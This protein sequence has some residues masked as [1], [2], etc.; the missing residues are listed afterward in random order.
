M[1]ETSDRPEPRAL[2]DAA[3]RRYYR[4]AEFH[5]RVSTAAKVAEAGQPDDYFVRWHGDS[6]IAGASVALHLADLRP[7]VVVPVEPSADEVERAAVARITGLLA[8]IPDASDVMVERTHLQ[9]LLD[10]IAA[11]RGPAGTSPDGAQG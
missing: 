7:A 5:S 4:D 2:M 1:T 6:L 9:A 8:R 3:G 10:S 11:M